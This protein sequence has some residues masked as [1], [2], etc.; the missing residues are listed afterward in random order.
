M[1][2]GR[3]AW[4]GGA[5]MLVL[6]AQ[7]V[8]AGLAGAAEE[9]SGRGR[10]TAVNESAGKF[11]S[12]YHEYALFIAGLNN[13]ESSLKQYEG[14]L[15]WARFA[16]EMDRIWERFTQKQF[17]VMQKWAAQELAAATTG[18]VFYPFSG[19][20]FVH[21]C[22]LFPQAQTYILVALEPVGELPDFA[23][24][25][26]ANFFPRLQ[27]SLYD[28]LNLSFFQTKKMAVS[29]SKHELKGVLPV[30]LLFL[31]RTKA[32]VLDVQQW[33]MRPDGAIEEI[34]AGQR[35]KPDK[36]VPG[37]RIVFTPEGSTEKRTLYYFSINLAND[38]LN[39]H[40]NFVAFLKSFGPVTSFAKAASYLMFGG[41][42]SMI[43]QLILDQSLYV[44]QSDTAIPFR[45][46]DPNMW[47]FRF[48]GTY[49]CPITLFRNCQQSD[50]VKIYRAKKDVYP[51]PFGICYH[52]RLNTSNLLFAAKKTRP[53]SE[54]AN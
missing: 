15:G 50:L 8:A 17:T 24:K 39:K 7:G 23:G 51:L 16:K 33:V 14:K 2:K 53:S 30:L 38:S 13:P 28:I 26:G 34:S 44:L 43:R 35:V 47:G 10:S 21:A 9:I 19:P 29:Y 41:H 20:D 31:A 4:W 48:Y 37:V 52:H 36:G 12:S 46:F 42:F 45:Y 27:R 18:T 49:S 40:P 1:A 5:V 3:L 22:A 54:A 6:L 11:A 25:D 32:Q